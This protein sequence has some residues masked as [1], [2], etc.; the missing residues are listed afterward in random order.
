MNRQHTDLI[1]V[2]CSA[3]KPN[4]NIGAREIRQ[5]HIQ[6]GWKDIGYQ[7]VIR[8][9]GDVENGRP[10]DQIGAHA[11]GVNDKSVGICLVGGIGSTG[12]A[13]NN[14]T[15]VQLRV[16]RVLC[17]G[18]QKKYPGAKVIGH[19]DVPGVTKDCPCFDVRSWYESDQ[20]NPQQPIH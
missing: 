6:R 18:L 14:F 1:V 17:T 10:V 5:W 3:T 9:N 20:A 4:Q 11:Y 12:L 7:Y 16:L 2:H 13:E 15:S 8:R 19:R